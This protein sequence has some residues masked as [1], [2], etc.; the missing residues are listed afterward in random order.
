MSH[1][2]ATFYRNIPESEDLLVFACFAF[3]HPKTA[4]VNGPGGT[5]RKRLI[6]GYPRTIATLPTVAELMRGPES[7]RFLRSVRTRSWWRRLEVLLSRAP[8]GR[9][10]RRPFGTEKHDEHVGLNRDPCRP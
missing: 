8:R 7:G 5:I 10:F 3:H 2:T 1:V 4:S 9:P 6:V